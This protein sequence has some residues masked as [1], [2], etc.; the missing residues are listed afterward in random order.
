MKRS[1]LIT[2]LCAVTFFVTGA[3][4]SNNSNI[5]RLRKSFSIGAKKF[6][7]LLVHNN[8]E[9]EADFSDYNDM[10]N[11]VGYSKNNYLGSVRDYFTDQSMGKFDP[12]FVVYHVNVNED[13][14]YYISNK[15]ETSELVQEALISLLMK[16]PDFNAADY[17]SDND[18]EVD[19]VA[20]VFAG[21]VNNEKID[22]QSNI[23]PLFAGHRKV[24]KNHILLA[25]NKTPFAEFIHEFGHALGLYDL[26]STNKSDINWLETKDIQ[27]PGLHGWD[28]MSLGVDHGNGYVP[29]GYSAFERY[30][31]GWLDFDTLDLTADVISIPPLET[32]NKAYKIPVP[33][34]PKEWFILENRQKGKW[35]FVLPNHGLLIWHIDDNDSIWNGAL[36]DDPSHQYVDLIEA[37]SKK[38]PNFNVG[39]EKEYLD[40]DSFPGSENVTEFGGFTAWSGIN[41]GINLYGIMEENKNVCFTTKKTIVVKTCDVPEKTFK[42]SGSWNQT[43]AEESSIEPIII[44]GVENFARNSWFIYFLN[45]DYQEAEG[46]VTITSTVPKY[47][48][49]EVYTESFTINGEVYE[50]SLNVTGAT[51]FYAKPASVTEEFSTNAEI[52]ALATSAKPGVDFHLQNENLQISATGNTR[53]NIAVFDMLGNK[54]YTADFYETSYNIN[55]ASFKNKALVVRITENGVISKQRRI[56]VK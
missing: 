36:N 29:P 25:Q 1:Y 39:G 26:Y 28:V 6:P 18:G 11:K 43:V 30:F 13:L 21:A 14:S 2:T 8:T 49:P 31:L 34:N 19:V 24:F 4:A 33:N 9:P 5:E 40:D 53:K 48:K 15:R 7:V 16:Y 42:I 54:V 32:S 35:D 27:A 47:T 38:V 37:G 45:I 46:T 12:T 56:D 44:S 3:F 20:V 41:L 23:C 17:D 52:T 55:L 10:L 22:Y 50:L 51:H